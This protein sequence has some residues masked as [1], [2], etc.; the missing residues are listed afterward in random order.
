MASFSGR[1]VV[2]SL[3]P[4]PLGEMELESNAIKHG[5]L[6]HCGADIRSSA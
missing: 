5:N 6:S 4:V 2:L 1:L 3:C